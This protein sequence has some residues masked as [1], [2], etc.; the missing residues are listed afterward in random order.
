VTTDNWVIEQ[1]YAVVLKTVCDM[2][3]AEKHALRALKL[4]PA[5]AEANAILGALYLKKR[6]F[7]M[8]ETY[9][10]KLLQFGFPHLE[11]LFY[12]LGIAC[13]GQGKYAEAENYLLRTLKIRGNSIPALYA[14]ADVYRD[15]GNIRRALEIWRKI[16]RLDSAQVEAAIFSV[17]D[18]HFS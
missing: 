10:Q 13:G 2:D 8:A 16:L 3:L 5:D 18:G 14:L 15:T 7:S 12:Q 11:E 1:N 6:Q 4:Y 9:L 17:D